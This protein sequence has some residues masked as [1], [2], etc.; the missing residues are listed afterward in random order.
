MF[1]NVANVLVLHTVMKTIKPPLK[2]IGSYC[3]QLCTDFVGQSRCIDWPPDWLADWPTDWSNEVTHWMT[4]WKNKMTDWLDM[5]ADSTH[6]FSVSVSIMRSPGARVAPTPRSVPRFSLHSNVKKN[7]QTLKVSSFISINGASDCPK[8]NLLQPQRG[9]MRFAFP[10]LARFTIHL[11]RLLWLSLIEVRLKIA[12]VNSG[13]PS[14]IIKREI[15]AVDLFIFMWIFKPR[16]FQKLW[17]RKLYVVPQ[18][19]VY[20]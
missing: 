4:E 11:V 12:G 20:W 2:L 13:A 1:V 19:D 15:I 18:Q 5:E 9:N 17:M 3:E 14:W 8:P 6:V 10:V 7:R 16:L